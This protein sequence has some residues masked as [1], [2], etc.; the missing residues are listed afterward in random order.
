MTTFKNEK[1]IFADWQNSTLQQ[2]LSQPV[3]TLRKGT[4]I[5]PKTMTSVH[6]KAQSD[7]LAYLR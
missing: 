1:N 7:A 6:A 5:V 4:Q 2:K 3:S